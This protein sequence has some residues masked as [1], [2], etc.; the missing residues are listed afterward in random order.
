MKHLWLILI[1][2]FV[3]YAGG[4]Y[5]IIYEAINKS[6]YHCLKSVFLASLL[7][8]FIITDI[9]YYKDMS[10]KETETVVAEY[11]RFQSSNTW[12][13]TRTVFFEDES[14][15]LSVYFATYAREVG[16]MEEGA[17]YEVEYFCNSRVVKEYKLLESCK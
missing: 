11:V 4:I 9:P 5:G 16:N 3:V 2:T 6:N 1:P 12:P 8:Y 13:F 17:V 15:E 14:G 7:V 10:K